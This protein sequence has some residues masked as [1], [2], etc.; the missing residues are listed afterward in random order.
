MKEDGEKD[1]SSSVKE[2]FNE[3]K[4]LKKQKLEVKA[5]KSRGNKTKQ[6][7]QKKGNI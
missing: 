2:T 4:K 3:K 6:Q 5:K 7:G 1:D